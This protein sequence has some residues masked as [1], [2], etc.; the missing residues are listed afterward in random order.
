MKRN[1]SFALL[2]VL[3]AFGSCSFTTK[4][5]NDPNKD[6][7]LIQIITMALEQLHFEPKSVDDSFSKEVYKDFLNAVDPF[8][9]YFTQDDIKSF[10]VYETQIDD[11][12][13]NY[14]ITFFNI[15]YDKLMLRQKESKKY[16]QDILAKPFDFTIDETINADYKNLDFTKN[17]KE[18]VDRWRKQ[19][20]LSTLS[21]YEE[22]IEQKEE[23]NKADFDAENTTEVKDMTLAQLEEKAREENLKTLDIYYTDYL[24][25][26]DREDWFSMFVNVIVEE[27]DPHTSYLAPSDKER[28]DQQISGKLEGIGARLSKRLNYIKIV[29]LIS[30]GPAWRGEELEVEDVILKVRQEDEKE[31]VSVVGMRIDDAIELIKGPKGTKV[32]LTVKKVDG[33]IE[34]ITITRDLVELEETYAKSTVINKDDMAYGL[35]NLPSFY[36]DFEDYNKRNAAT[37]VRKEIERLKAQNVEGL[38]IDLRSNGG[39]SLKTVVDIAGLFIKEG[40]I[41]QVRSAGQPQEVL[42]DT[43]DAVIWDGPLVIMVNELSASASEILAAAMQDYKRAIII[44][45]KQTYGKGTVQ[46]VLPLN[47]MVRSNSHGDLGALKLTRQKF[48]RING[49]STQLK[50]VESDIVVPDRYS[51]IDIGERDQENPLAWD[52]IEPADYDYWKKDFN[53]DTTISQSIARMKNNQQLRLIDENAKWSRKQM[54]DKEY[55]LNFNKFKAEIDRNIKESKAFDDISEYKNSL[56]FSSLPY[57]KQL[58]EQDTI[59]KSKRERWHKNLTRDVYVDE[60]VNV[61]NDMISPYGIKKVANIKN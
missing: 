28:F 25:D 38:I 59:L 24:E 41:V 1:Y 27:Y 16:Y 60:A 36:V 50:G 37:D 21:S 52:K 2:L 14:D 19:L 10:K 58:F 17:K 23:E 39:G 6:K 55:S 57:E 20:K 42:K 34:D 45:S 61:L 48:Y 54:D 11:Q 46:N 29:E 5:D 40:P 9:R 15:V 3:F 33:R 31:A 53:Y 12:L 22:L 47:R 13:K 32:I 4:V 26:M 44:G 35:I 8:K 51:Y 43:D 30:G 56:S 49:G 18:L 7:L